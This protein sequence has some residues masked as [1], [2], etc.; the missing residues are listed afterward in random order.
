MKQIVATFHLLQFLVINKFLSS[1]YPNLTTTQSDFHK[2]AGTQAVK[3]T[4]QRKEVTNLNIHL[5]SQLK[6]LQK[7]CQP[8]VKTGITFLSLPTL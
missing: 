4:R 1:C 5:S 2:T 3:A 7:P 8:S 6:C